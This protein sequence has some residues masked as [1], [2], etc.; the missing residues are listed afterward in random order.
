MRGKVLSF[1]FFS[2]V[3]KLPYSLYI[4][5]RFKAFGGEKK[6]STKTCSPIC[7]FLILVLCSTLGVAI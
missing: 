3:Q 6:K 7:H 5:N 4:Q 2:L 1:L